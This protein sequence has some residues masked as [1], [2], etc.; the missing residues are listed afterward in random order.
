[1][2]TTRTAAATTSTTRTAA[3]TTF[4]T[5]TAAAATS[6]TASGVPSAGSLLLVGAVATVLAAAATAAVS[7]IGHAA[8]ASLALA[9][10][11]IPPPGFA[12]MTVLFA[13]L[14]LLLALAIRRYAASPRTLWLRTTIALTV[15]SWIPDLLADA[16]AAT[17]AILMTTHLV[18][19]AIV[20]PAV[21][22]R[23]RR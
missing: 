5:R 6:T 3:A 14:G 2:S 21:A 8:G 17:K 22:S 11:P 1:M 7:A 16:D 20:I 10:E 18:A 9:G 12:T 15:L 23:L 13:A 19:A 4:T